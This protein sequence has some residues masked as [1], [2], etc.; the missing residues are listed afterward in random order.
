MFLLLSDVAAFKARMD[1]RRKPDGRLAFDLNDYNT[2]ED[3]SYCI[4]TTINI[5]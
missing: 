2:F 4:N 5:R 1:E 3:V